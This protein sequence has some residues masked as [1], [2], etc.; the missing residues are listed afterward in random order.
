[1]LLLGEDKSRY[2]HSWASTALGVP[3]STLEDVA[4]TAFEAAKS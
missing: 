2:G 3:A 4:K 1:M